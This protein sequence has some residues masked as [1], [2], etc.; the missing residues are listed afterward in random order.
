MRILRL[1][2]CPLCR[3]LRLRV[4][5]S[6]S[7]ERNTKLAELSRRPGLTRETIEVA[8]YAQNIYLL[9]DPLFIDTE[10]LETATGVLCS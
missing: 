3:S 8:I 10:L 6:S 2:R 9:R 1:S 4:R 5:T 7:A